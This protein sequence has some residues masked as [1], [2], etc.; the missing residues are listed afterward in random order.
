[1]KE[2]REE[3]RTTHK[4]LSLFYNVIL[5]VWYDKNWLNKWRTPLG[6]RHFGQNDD[7]PSMF[8]KT[9]RLDSLQE[10]S[11]WVQRSL[12]GV[13]GGVL[14]CEKRDECVDHHGL[15]DRRVSVQMFESGQPKLAKNLFL[16]LN[17]CQVIEPYPDSPTTYSFQ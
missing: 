5:K 3:T 13:F 15:P 8:L 9:S 6:C 12:P 7:R 10:W 1:M 16:L 14:E 11:A 4:L 17:H 2:T